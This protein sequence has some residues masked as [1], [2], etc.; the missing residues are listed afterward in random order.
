VLKA[1][2]LTSQQSFLKNARSRASQPV[3]RLNAATLIA[4]R[5]QIK[6]VVRDP[7]LNYGVVACSAC[8]A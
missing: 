8:A 2:D 5:H 4:L 1:P 7:Y 6:V 3:C